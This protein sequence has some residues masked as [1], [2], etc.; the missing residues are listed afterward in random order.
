MNNSRARP[1]E[2]SRTLVLAAVNIGGALEWYEIGIF[3][4]WQLIIQQ[5]AVDF[6]AFAASANAGAILLLA[7]TVLASGGARAIGGWFFGKT[8]DRQ[9]RRAAFPLTILVA[10]CPSWGLVLL[11]FFLSYE[12][13]ITYSTVIFT[14]V[15]FFQG[16]PAGGELPGAICY[17]AEARANPNKARFWDNQRYMCSYAMLGPQIGLALS[18]IVCLVLRLFF[19]TDLLL[20]H[21]WRFVFLFSGLMGIGGFI[22]R[23]KLHETVAFREKKALHQIA[24][25]PLKTLFSKYKIQ[26]SSGALLSVFEVVTFSVLSITPLYY[27]RAPFHFAP[28][29]ITFISLGF[30]IFCIILLP[31]VGW[32]SSRFK[33][34]PWLTTSAWSVVPLSYVLYKALLNGNFPISLIV[35]VAMLFLFS[36]Q[37]A[38][39]PSLLAKLFPVQIRYTGIAFS[40]NIC[41]GVLW[42]VVTS[43]C[44][45]LMSAGNP[46]FILLVPIAAGLFL[47]SFKY[48]K[49]TKK[50][51]FEGFL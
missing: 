45:W 5:N 10:T 8:G 37:A 22:I 27:S 29:E 33:S 26:L 36:V 4:A 42:T 47:I 44:F 14:V 2:D 19:S 51:N 18:T 40:F 39:L 1:S 49:Y 50:I 32:L 24:S 9:G 46:R 43:T 17:L 28:R 21:I 6:D 25:S 23:K 3:I 34:F 12:E 20:H 35:S 13:W 30:S 38:I 7:A 31:L 11:S 41:D 48:F 15:K 16:M